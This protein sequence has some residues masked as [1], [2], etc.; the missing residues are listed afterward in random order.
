MQIGSVTD[1]KFFCKYHLTQAFRLFRAR[2]NSCLDPLKVHKS[3]IKTR[4]Q[5]ITE[6]FYMKCR[7]YMSIIPGQKL[8]YNCATVRV[9]EWLEQ[10]QQLNEIYS[11]SSQSQQ[12]ESYP[13][14]SQFSSAESSTIEEL[15]SDK[16]MDCIENLQNMLGISSKLQS[17]KVIYIYAVAS[18]K[19]Y[20]RKYVFIFLLLF[21]CF[22]RDH[23][24]KHFHRLLN[25]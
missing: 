14:N 13:Q 9:P 4:L 16:A 10:Q 25:L 11:S 23:W 19:K 8:C 21:V 17:N 6:E 18:W 2:Q 22:C 12:T 1:K 5:D 7:D 24:Q 20:P 3:V 15:E